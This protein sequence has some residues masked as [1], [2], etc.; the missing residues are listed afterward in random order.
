MF[1]Q[2]RVLVR[3]QQYI[4][5]D[6]QIHAC[7][8]AG[9]YGRG[10]NDKFSDLDLILLFA[11]EESRDRA[12]V[13]RH[14]FVISVLPYLS[15]KS[16]DADHVKPHMHIALYGNGAKVDFTYETVNIKPQ[17]ELRDMRILKESGGW[18]SAFLH[19]CAA[20]A[21]TIEKATTAADTLTAIDDRFWIMFMDVYRQLL[22]GDHD[23]PF[24]IYI[25]MI[26]FTIPELLKLL[27]QEDPAY[28]ALFEIHYSQDTGA[29]IKHM[30]RLM[31]AYLGARDAFV[32]RHHLHFQADSNFERVLL[33][34]IERA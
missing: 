12:Y 3:L 26:Y 14:Q 20:Q 24:P 30:Q 15:A 6:E 21:P 8:L 5:Q 17:F 9:S 18:A 2:D 22:R 23:A 10:K 28:Q 32:K 13:Q 19:E 4:L 16:F 7:F 29:T 31:R 25:Q 33:K 34:K 1:E 27:P 11:D